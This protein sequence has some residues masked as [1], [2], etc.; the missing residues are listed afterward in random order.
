[1]RAIYAGGYALADASP[2]SDAGRGRAYAD[3]FASEL[4]PPQSILEVG[5]GSGALL[6][7]LSSR[8]PNAACTGTDPSLSKTARSTERLRLHRSFVEDMPA[9]AKNFDLIVA[10]NVIEH[11]SSSGIIFGDLAIQTRRERTNCDRTVPQP[12]WRTRN[13]SFTIIFTA[14][15]HRLSWR[16]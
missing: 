7:E 13:C 10:V 3:W 8:W 16:R 9:D 6:R 4:P 1:M 15:R 12:N 14:L 2:S 11:T 5:C